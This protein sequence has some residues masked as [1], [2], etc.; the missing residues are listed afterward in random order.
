MT[1]FNNLHLSAGPD[2][3]RACI[4]D[5]SET[6]AGNAF[7]TE[8]TGINDVWPEPTPLPNAATLCR[9]SDLP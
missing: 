4:D 5:A 6:V 8:A 3:V 9:W 1:D 2:A 7:D